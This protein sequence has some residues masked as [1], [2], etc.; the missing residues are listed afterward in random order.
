MTALR[1]NMDAQS[2]VLYF[3]TIAILSVG[4]GFA[5][6]APVFNQPA[7]PVEAAVEAAGAPAA[8]ERADPLVRFQIERAA[9][10]EAERASLRAVMEDPSSD[11]ALVADAGARLIKI[12]TWADQEQTIEGVLRAKGY[13]DCVVTVHQDSCN[14]MI[15][16]DGPTRRQAAQILELVSRETGLG[17]GNIKI[18]PVE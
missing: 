10:R 1:L 11:A 4:L 5:V 18:I 17:G 8:T 14:V 12:L 6:L 13:A 15:R 16:A 9:M 3:A 2:K 7:R